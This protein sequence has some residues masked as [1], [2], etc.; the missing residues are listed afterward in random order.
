PRGSAARTTRSA[1]PC[2]ERVAPD[3]VPRLSVARW[4]FGRRAS[5]RPCRAAPARRRAAFRGRCRADV[6]VEVFRTLKE[7]ICGRE[8]K[9]GAAQNGGLGFARGEAEP[10]PRASFIVRADGVIVNGLLFLTR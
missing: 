9:I 6:C 3:S 2:P 4:R 1:S 10:G 8:S 5:S 7:K